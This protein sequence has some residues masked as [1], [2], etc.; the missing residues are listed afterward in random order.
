MKGKGEENE[1]EK[2][3]R[4]KLRHR[5]GMFDIHLDSEGRVLIRA[6]VFVCAFV[7]KRERVFHLKENEEEMSDLPL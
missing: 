7:M 4:K 3:M 6:C 1:R 2:I 5:A